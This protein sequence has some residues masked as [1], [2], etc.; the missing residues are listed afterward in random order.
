MEQAMTGHDYHLQAIL[1]TLALHRW[2]KFKL[3]NYDYHTHIGGAYYLFIRGMSQTEPGNGVYF[4]LPEQPMIE[5]LD[6]LFS[7]KASSKTEQGDNSLESKKEL[8][9]EK[10]PD[11]NN[12]PESKNE[13]EL[14]NSPEPK[15]KA[16]PNK[17]P[18]QQGQLDLW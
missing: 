17:N 9:P 12:S 18:Q 4:V 8:E 11:P 10:V 1:Y 2:L 16:E 5:A 13:P 14:N 6:D 7:G 3:P 15:D